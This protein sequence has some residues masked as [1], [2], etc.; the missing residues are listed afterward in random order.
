MDK[1]T[2]ELVDGRWYIV[3]PEWTGNKEDLEMVL[4]ADIL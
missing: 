1:Y 4:G 3:L 2:F